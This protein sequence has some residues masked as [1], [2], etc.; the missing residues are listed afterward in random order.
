MRTDV[1]KD[2]MLIRS[3]YQLIPVNFED[4]I[5]IKALAD[6][7]IIK[8]AKG[9]HITLCTM[10]EVEEKLPSERFARSHRSFIVN[11]NKVSFIRGN[12]IEIIDRDFRFSI[13]IGR[14]YKRDFRQS[15]EVA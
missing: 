1:Q 10:K 9:K 6:Y 5:F 4:I 2:R 8:T 3:D 12:N 7:I 11:L 14:A 13:P 15:L